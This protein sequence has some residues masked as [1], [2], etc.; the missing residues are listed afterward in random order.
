MPNVLNLPFPTFQLLRETCPMIVRATRHILYQVKS[1]WLTYR[2]RRLMESRWR[3]DLSRSGESTPT[4]TTSTM[5]KYL[6]RISCGYTTDQG[7]FWG[8]HHLSTCKVDHS[9]PL[10][11]FHDQTAF[12]DLV[13]PKG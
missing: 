8:M 7:L 10:R 5:T 11:L 1:M 13:S 3:E 2:L 6:K 9:S 4:S 12:T